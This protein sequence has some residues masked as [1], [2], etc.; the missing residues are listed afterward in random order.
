MYKSQKQEN[1]LVQ[2][3][4][5]FRKTRLRSRGSLSGTLG[6]PLRWVVVMQRLLLA[7][8]DVVA[9][10]GLLAAG[11]VMDRLAFEDVPD[12]P[13][14]RGIW[15]Q[16][17][18]DHGLGAHIS[19]LHKLSGVDE[20]G[21]FAAFADFAVV[22]L[23]EPAFPCAHVDAEILASRLG[24]FPWGAAQAERY[25]AYSN[26]P[27]VGGSWVVISFS[28]NDFRCHV[29]FAAD[30]PGRTQ[31]DFCV[32][33]YDALSSTI[34][35]PRVISAEDFA[36]AEICN[37]QAPVACDEATVV[38]RVNSPTSGRHRYVD[39]MLCSVFVSHQQPR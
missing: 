5:G 28:L 15:M 12:G 21:K 19:E 20:R 2:R 3:S 17:A 25:V 34:A 23:V 10:A 27:D 31:S 13:P 11:E 37:L 6:L 32:G 4:L 7:F 22:V 24:R 18:K 38:T 1:L 8:S 36:C 29:R 9:V 39:G 14:F 35:K 26:R 16:H 33:T 30:P